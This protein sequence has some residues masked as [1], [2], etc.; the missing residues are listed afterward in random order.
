MA[1]ELPPRFGH[2]TC[3]SQ[4]PEPS[5]VQAFIPKLAVEVS[6]EAVVHG[7]PGRIKA[8][9]DL[10]ISQLAHDPLCREL[11]PVVRTDVL[12][13]V[14][15]AH[16][17]WQSQDHVL[18]VYRGRHPDHQTFIG[19]LAHHAQEPNGALADHAVMHE[20]VVSHTVGLG[21]TGQ[22]DVSS[23][24][25]TSRSPLE[26][27]QPQLTPRP[28][29]TRHRL[30]PSQAAVQFRPSITKL[31]GHQV[32]EFGVLALQ[33]LQPPGIGCFPA[34]IL[35][36]RAEEGLLGSVVLAAQLL[37]LHTTGLRLPKNLDNLFLRRSLLHL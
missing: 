10:L 20:V 15:Q 2:H 4:I 12:G 36:A 27:V 13:L 29:H 19:V 22:G 24:A 23:T 28:A 26:Q 33:L 3:F 35:V 30:V 11:R 14:I 21:G 25:P 31:L 5:P 16:Q 18:R 7:L 17:R 1:V 6:H 34:A 32:L 37:D 9:A 8:R